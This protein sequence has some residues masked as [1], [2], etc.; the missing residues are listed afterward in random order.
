MKLTATFVQS[1][2]P[3]TNQSQSEYADAGQR[4]LVLVVSNTAKSWILRF[5]LHGK[6][7]RFVL[8]R[9]P[10]MSLADARK[11]ASTSMASVDAG[12][13]PAGVAETIDAAWGRYWKTRQSELKHPAADL[14][15]FERHIKPTVGGIALGSLNKS[16]FDDLQSAWVA[17]GLGAGQ[18]TPYRVLKHFEGWLLDRD[19]IDRAFIPRRVVLPTGASWPVPPIDVVRDLL[20]W[21]RS[22]KPMAATQLALLA[23]TGARRTMITDLRWDEVDRDAEVFRWPADRMKNGKAFE[24]PVSA[25]CA[26]WLDGIKR[27]SSPFVFPSRRDPKKVHAS[28]VNRFAHGSPLGRT[29]PVHSL[30]KTLA[31]WAA[32]EGASDDLIGLLLSHTPSGVTSIYQK[33][34]RLEE[35]RAVL[36]A[37]GRAVSAAVTFT[38]CSP[39]GT[40]AS[41]RK[42][43]LGAGVTREQM[44]VF[45]KVDVGVLDRWED[46]IAP[47]PD[48]VLPAV[49]VMLAGS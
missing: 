48:T 45:L 18:A 49:M 11:K 28:S 20:A 46:E 23:L 15:T 4:G 24:Q 25:A 13:D 41:L 38:G 30:R 39:Y 3:K 34:S 7:K 5:S 44:A 22:Q 14:S 37:Y 9:Y 29:Y 10:E 16:H 33:S 35:R 8:G 17:S 6:R 1:C 47:V 2:S 19:L 31:T 32:E 27:T 21:C 42:M 26:V 40:G 36:D 43:R 12:S